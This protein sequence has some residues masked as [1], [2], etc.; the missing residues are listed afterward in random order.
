[1]SET[2]W[3]VAALAVGF[4]CGLWLAAIGMRDDIR[5]L[6]CW[7]VTQSIECYQGRPQ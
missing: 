4:I 3:V 1:M 5:E 7:R 6:E 2:G